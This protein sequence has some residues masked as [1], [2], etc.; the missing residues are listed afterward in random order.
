ML[1]RV[2]AMKTP[3][4][5]VADLVSRKPKAEGSG[6]VHAVAP[7]TMT[8]EYKPDVEEPHIDEEATVPAQTAEQAEA[9]VENAEAVLHSDSEPA[10][11]EVAETVSALESRG[12]APEPTAAPHVTVDK[13]RAPIE[14]DEIP[15]KRAPTRAKKMAPV[16]DPVAFIEQADEAGPVPALASGPKSLLDEMAELDAEVAGL[17]RQLAKKLTEQNA[18]LRKMLA[19]FDPR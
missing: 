16:A 18:Q 4:K 13:S 14:T 19:R 8:L 9:D 1:G 10:A 6:E 11:D 5:F 17:R 12:E 2:D 15:E 3:W 7:D